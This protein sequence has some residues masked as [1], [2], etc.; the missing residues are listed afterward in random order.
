MSISRRLGLAIGLFLL[1]GILLLLGRWYASTRPAPGHLADNVAVS[2]TSGADR[3][4]GSLREA[5]FVADAAKDRASI[6]IRVSKIALETA[7]PPLVNPHGISITAP[8]PGTEIDA[9]ALNGA[10]VFDVDGANSSISGVAIRNCSG[11]AILLRATHF[12]LQAAAVEAC[13]VGVDVAENGS[14]I[15]LEGNR[16]ARNRVGVRFG[17]SNHNAEV[18]RN[19]FSA[20]TDA[21]LWAIRSNPD[22]RRDAISVHDNRFSDDRMGIAAG[23]VSMLVE[24]NDFN[25]EREVA[26]HL[27]GAGI[28]VRGNRI[29]G[30]AA[31]GIIAENAPAAVIETN[32]IDHVSA[33]G[34]MVR[35]SANTLVKGNR[36]HHCGYGMAFVLGDMLKPSTAVDNTIIEPKYHGIDV[37]GDSPILRRNHVLNAHASPLHVADF[38]PPDRPKVQAH[39]LLD[40]NTFESGEAA[41]AKEAAGKATATVTTR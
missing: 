4:P 34:I 8:A 17:A 3:G 10:P 7:L 13:D 40:G 24:H 20:D 6:S 12:H 18:T 26:V 23:N 15:L 25:N 19:E 29:R 35:G 36:I 38:E 41:V 28:A 32:E 30:G 22:M 31:M 27:M 39:P 9:R 33:Y 14:D 16:F 21:G 5:L 2:V 11:P 37:V 1:L